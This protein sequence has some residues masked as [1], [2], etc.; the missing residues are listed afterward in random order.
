MWNSS[1]IHTH[2]T[3]NQI[4]ASQ[5]P[6]LKSL[7]S[8][9]G[10]TLWGNISEPIRGYQVG[11][12]IISNYP[13]KITSYIYAILQKKQTQLRLI[14]IVNKAQIYPVNTRCRTH[15]TSTHIIQSIKLGHHKFFKPNNSTNN[16]VMQA[17]N[18][19]GQQGLTL[20][21]NT[22]FLQLC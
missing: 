1:H 7:T 11:F 17:R 9:L 16:V 20:T 10:L 19:V 4:G 3:I 5:S 13:R 12:D 22:K 14:V 21:N 15:H 2:H 6:P 8:S 18:I